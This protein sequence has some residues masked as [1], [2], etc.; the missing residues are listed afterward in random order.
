MKR[1]SLFL[2]SIMIVLQLVA[3]S[4]RYAE[5]SVLATGDWY[6]IQVEQY[7]DSQDEIIYPCL[8]SVKS[9]KEIFITPKPTPIDNTLRL[10]FYVDEETFDYDDSVPVF[11]NINSVTNEY[12]INGET[13]KLESNTSYE[14][15]INVSWE[16][17]D[18]YRTKMP[19]MDC[20]L[21]YNTF[22]TN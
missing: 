20:Y 6:K 8:S 1:I 17:N 21:P 18:T 7:L 22:N 10:S 2:L 13:I 9:S 3:Q 15:T 19:N 14:N 11:N 4:S 16:Y 12:T 5:S